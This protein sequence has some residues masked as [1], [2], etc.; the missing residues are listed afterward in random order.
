MTKIGTRFEPHFGDAATPAIRNATT[1]VSSS[2]AALDFFGVDTMPGGRSVTESSTM[3]ISAAYSCVRIIAGA[4]ASLPLDFYRRDVEKGSAEKIN[5]KDSLWWLFNEEPSARW[6][7]ANFWKY[8]I[9]SELLRGDAFAYIMRDRNGEVRGLEPMSAD[10][11]TVELS[12]EGLRYYWTDDYGRRRGA[13]Q[14]DVLHFPGFGFDGTRGKSAIQWGA[15]NSLGTAIALEEFAAKFFGNGALQ[16]FVVRAPGV[17][18]P[19]QIQAFKDAWA[20]KASG[21]DN[22]YRPP[23]LTEGLDVK[24]LQLSAEDSQVLESRK[25]QVI[26]IARAFGVPPFMIGESEKTSS[27]GSGVEAMSLG[28]VK[29][30]LGERLV[31]IEQEINRKVFRTASRFVKFGLD[32]LLRG[33][34]AAR[35]KFLRELVGGSSG[36]GVITTNEARRTEGFPPIA[37]GDKLYSPNPSTGAPDNAPQPN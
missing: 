22:A 34:S 28:F 27:W 11:T 36:P 33:D 32:D 18:S 30:T 29:Y 37:G 12:P 23:I 1:V 8:A 21:L 31:S 3:R 13:Y 19:E 6:T 16:Q 7:A 9:Q 10:R 24:E 25:F 2:P 15:R 26:D 20:N 35:A 17:M 14:D 4:I 5:A